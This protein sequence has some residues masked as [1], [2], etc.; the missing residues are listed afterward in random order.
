MHLVHFM[1]M[2]VCHSSMVN[3][4]LLTCFASYEWTKYTFPFVSSLLVVQTQAFKTQVHFYKR[5]VSINS[6]RMN[7]IWNRF[8]TALPFQVF[9]VCVSSLWNGN[10]VISD[11]SYLFSEK[12]TVVFVLPLIWFTLYSSKLA[13]LIVFHSQKMLLF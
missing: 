7:T 9:F 4:S 3:T 11:A 6:I 10:A 8:Y 1:A 5:I 12:L 13:D 2:N